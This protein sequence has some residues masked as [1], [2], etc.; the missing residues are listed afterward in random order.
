MIIGTTDSQTRRRMGNL[1]HLLILIQDRCC[2][3]KDRQQEGCDSTKQAVTQSFPAPLCDLCVLCGKSPG[4]ALVA[5][6]LL[7]EPVQKLDDAGAIDVVL[8]KRHGDRHAIAVRRV[9][10]NPPGMAIHGTDSH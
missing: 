8:E 1:A 4:P 6:Q 5:R 2:A 7:L 10:D 3:D 9:R